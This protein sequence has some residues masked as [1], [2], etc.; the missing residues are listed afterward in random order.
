M[1][2]VKKDCKLILCFLDI[3]YI[4]ICFCVFECVC[5][6]FHSH[7]NLVIFILFFR[8]AGK[9]HP[10][11]FGPINME[12]LLKLCCSV[13]YKMV[14]TNSNILQLCSATVSFLWQG[15]VWSVVVSFVKMG[16]GERQ[17]NHSIVFFAI[18]V[19]FS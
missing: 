5:R 17:Y 15:K 4:R 7:L 8:E 10:E 16:F 3:L 6:L 1:T 14:S 2:H 9:N 19:F 11:Y 13:Q 12:F 18:I